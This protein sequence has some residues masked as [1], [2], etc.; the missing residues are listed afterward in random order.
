ME[1]IFRPSGAG[2]DQNNAHISLVATHNSIQTPPTCILML[3][4]VR[5]SCKY[6]LFVYSEVELCDITNYI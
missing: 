6:F 4:H 1:T 3:L 5:L 2:G